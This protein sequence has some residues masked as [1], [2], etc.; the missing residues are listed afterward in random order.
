MDLP[1]KL[2]ARWAAATALNTALPAT[3][4]FTG[5]IP[6]DTA[7]PCARLYIPGSTAGKLSDKAAERAVQVRFIHW[8]DEDDFG[9]GQ[10]IQDAIEEAFDNYD[11][12][13]EDSTLVKL[14]HDNSFHIQPEDPNDKSFQFVT[15][16]TATVQKDRTL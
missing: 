14:R 15:Q 9:D 4:L 16:F 7:N 3:R 1:A 8:V 11:V 5:R 6:R 13:L 10:D 12:A 2:H